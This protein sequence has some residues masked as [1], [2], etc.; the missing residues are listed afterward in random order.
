M[1]AQTKIKLIVS[2]RLNKFLLKVISGAGSEQCI[3]YN[4]EIVIL[5][6]IKILLNQ[7][8]KLFISDLYW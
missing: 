6:A 8:R 1:L 7:D 3:F 2:Y 4:T 5:I